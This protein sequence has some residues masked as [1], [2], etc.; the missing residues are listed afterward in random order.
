MKTHRFWICNAIAIIFVSALLAPP[1]VAAAEAELAKT[2]GDSWLLEEPLAQSRDPH[3]FDWWNNRFDI[4]AGINAVNESNNFKSQSYNFGLM[5]GLTNAVA[6]R[7]VYRQIQVSGS[8]SSDVVG[9]TPY[10]QAAQSAHSELMLGVVIPLLA[11]R[12]FTRFSPWMGDLDHVLSFIAG[13]HYSFY[14]TLGHPFG[15]PAPDPLAGQFPITY[16]Y[17]GEA[18]LQLKVGLPHAL[19]AFVEFEYE[20]PLSA[21]NPDLPSWTTLGG[22]LAWSFG[23]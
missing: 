20:I 17:A 23:E 9:Q 22:G 8:A 16:R 3:F 10:A 7:A 11:G 18:G 1:R 13:G 19:S 14:P 21:R 15:G 12:S 2:G 5:Y 6:L 4:E